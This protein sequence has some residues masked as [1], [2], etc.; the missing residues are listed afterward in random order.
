ME[1][2]DAGV[3]IVTQDTPSESFTGLAALKAL[4][5]NR[6][7]AEERVLC[8]AIKRPQCQSRIF[9]ATVPGERQRTAVRRD[10]PVSSARRGRSLASQKQASRRERNSETGGVSERW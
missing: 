3:H 5:S 10:P 9:R 2:L 7:N 8:S 1:L 6:M 4:V